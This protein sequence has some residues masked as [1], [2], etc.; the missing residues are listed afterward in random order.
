MLEFISTVLRGQEPSTTRFT[1]SFTPMNVRHLEHYDLPY[2]SVFGCG[3]TGHALAGAC[4]AVVGAG[5]SCRCS[6]VEDETTT[7]DLATDCPD[8][9][10]SYQSEQSIRIV[11]F[12][13]GRWGSSF[14]YLNHGR[15][16]PIHWS[17]FIP[18]Q[19][20]LNLILALG[21]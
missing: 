17:T 7:M 11:C 13:V 9:I 12:Y 14:V 20:N 8:Q 21:A 19:R 1:V 3:E 6:R 2:C 16:S 10:L 5:G 4:A 15:R 18:L